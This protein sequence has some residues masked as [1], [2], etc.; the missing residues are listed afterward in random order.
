PNKNW[1]RGR[2]LLI[3]DAAHPTTPNLGQGG[4]LAIE[5]AA[6]LYHLFSNSST[7]DEILPA[8]VKLR[9]SRAAAINRDSK[10]LGS[11]GQWSGKIA[12]W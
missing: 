8:F 4:C 1:Y 11:T 3:G 2:C 9:Y 10:R 5:D 6:C 7:L 12:C